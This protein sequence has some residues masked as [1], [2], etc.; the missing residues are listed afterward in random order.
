M[1]IKF[2][3]ARK[4]TI[5]I[6]LSALLTGC[7]GEDVPAKTKS[8]DWYKANET[9]REVVLEKCRQNPGE[10]GDT[11]DCENAWAAFKELSVGTL[12]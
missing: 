3:C 2:S 5:A 11:A 4:A 12:K 7:F 1:D 9:E 6:S 8:V 10:L